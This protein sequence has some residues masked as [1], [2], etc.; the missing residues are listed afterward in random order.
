MDHRERSDRRIGA[1]FAS[2]GAAG[3]TGAG[4]DHRP[5]SLPVG[6]AA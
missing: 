4:R 5:G 1:G 3:A 6:G 2:L